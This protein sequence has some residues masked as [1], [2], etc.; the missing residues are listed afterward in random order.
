M[1]RAEVRVHREAQSELRPK[2]SRQV[3]RHTAARRLCDLPPIRR[4]A[5]A[6]MRH[7]ETRR[8][9]HGTSVASRPEVKTAPIFSLCIA[10]GSALEPVRQNWWR[11]ST[12]CTLIRTGGARLGP[13]CHPSVGSPSIL[14]PWIFGAHCQP[15][16]ERVAAT[17]RKDGHA[18]ERGY[19]GDGAPRPGVMAAIS[20]QGMSRLGPA[21]G[22]G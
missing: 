15:R 12:V 19:W 1:Q 17:G 10:H 5:Y 20:H 9:E 14:H 4:P 13:P 3:T 6:D 11:L 22:V 8:S 16:G 18:R 21:W 2:A 7:A